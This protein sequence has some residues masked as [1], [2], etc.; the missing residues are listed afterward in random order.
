M[1]AA[2]FADDRQIVEAAQGAFED[3]AGGAHL[4]RQLVSFHQRDIGKPGCSRRRVAGIGHT[5]QEQPARPGN[6]LVDFIRHDGGRHGLIARGQALG[7]G[8]D[9]R[10]H[11]E[12]VL[13]R[14]EM[15]QAAEGGHHLVGD[16]LDVV[17]RADRGHAGVVAFRRHDDAAGAHDRLGNEG[18]DVFRAD[19]FDGG[20]QVLHKRV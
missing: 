4:F 12:H 7:R 1:A 17:F 11:A 19:V 5:V 14:K 18:G 6:H 20:L 2:D 13:R 3:L 15:T 10:R 8:D 9:V 16:V